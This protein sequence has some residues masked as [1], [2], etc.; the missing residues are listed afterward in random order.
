M[1]LAV[2]AGS[3]VSACSDGTSDPS[4]PAGK[5]LERPGPDSDGAG[6]EADS[7]NSPAAG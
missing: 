4:N 1:L 6:K 5:S 3:A 2:T 7:G